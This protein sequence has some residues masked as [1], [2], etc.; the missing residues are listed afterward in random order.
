M[1]IRSNI[2]YVT[3]SN[4]RAMSAAQIL[5]I[6]HLASYLYEQNPTETLTYVSSGGNLSPTMTDSRKAAGAATSGASFATA[7]A[8]PDITTIND[9]YDRVSK[10][11]VTSAPAEPN[12]NANLNAFPC[13]WDGDTKTIKVMTKDDFFDTFIGPTIT[14]GL[15]GTGSVNKLASGTY[16]VLTNSASVSGNPGT[17]IVSTNPI[18]IDKVA[19]LTAYTAAG[20]PETLDQPTTNTSYYLHKITQS[21]KPTYQMPLFVKS[22]GSGVQQYTTAN[23]EALVDDFIR[24]ATFGK[25]G[26]S[27]QHEMGT[28]VSNQ[29]GTN[30]NDRYYSGT[31]AS[32]YTQYL[33]TGL[34][35]RTQEFPNGSL[36]NA[37]TYRLGITTG[38]TYTLTANKST[39][40][41][42]NSTVIFTLTAA[43]VT[44]S[45]IVGTVTGVQ[46]AD[47]DSGN[48]TSLSPNFVL[49][50]SY[51]SSS[52]TVTYQVDADSLTEGTETMTL[53]V[54]GRSVQVTISDTSTTFVETVSLEGTSGS[55]EAS[56]S[57]PFADGSLDLGWRFSTNGTVEDYD[58]DNSPQYSSTG[59]ADWINTSS[60][61]Q[62][63]YIRGTVAS[64]SGSQANAGSTLNTWLGLNSNRSFRFTDNRASGSYATASLTYK[65]EIASDSG[66]STIVATGYY[67]ITYEGGA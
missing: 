9:T 20:I 52:A 28:S 21:S 29:K 30:I 44:P 43:N 56:G 14:D 60:P 10:T 64:Q 23:F 34:D 54:A 25:N 65:I 18:F 40:N 13:Y 45:T 67:N 5:E 11:R 41:E 31:S 12:E 58:S 37:T 53:A 8:T 55:P 16:T 24:S 57:F 62:T 26:F 66:G 33:A 17:T 35:Y 36:A 49:S 6:K 22:D 32:G 3:G 27:I 42:D 50:G 61:S 19:N 48:E 2:L 63:Y 1:A 4:L 39:I 51:S 38:A 46:S 15:V 7:A 47:F 59:H